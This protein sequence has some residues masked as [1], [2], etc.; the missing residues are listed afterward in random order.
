MN[1]VD[2][3][4]LAVLAE[5]EVALVVPVVNEVVPVVSEVVPVERAAL[6]D[7]ETMLVLEVSV[8]RRRVPALCFLNSS[9]SHLD[10]RASKKTN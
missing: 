3:V 9:W 2:P 8:V 6:V 4:E 5:S 10:C 7:R 1:E